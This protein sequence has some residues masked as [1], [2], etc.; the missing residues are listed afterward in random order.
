MLQTLT[1][2]GQA[3]PPAVQQPTHKAQVNF[4]YTLSDSFLTTMLDRHGVKVIGAYMANEGF[5][6]VHSAATSTAPATFIASARAE[7]AS[8]FTNGAGDGT[9]TRARDF[10][11]RHSTQDIGQDTELQTRAQSLVD[12]HTRLDQAR[13]NAQGTAALIYAVVVTGSKS[14]LV[15]LGE[16]R[17]VVDFEIADIDT[18][19]SWSQPSLQGGTTGQSGP[20]SFVPER[21]RTALPSVHTGPEESVVGVG[22]LGRRRCHWFRRDNSLRFVGLIQSCQYPREEGRTKWW[23]ATTQQSHRS[24]LHGHSVAGCTVSRARPYRSPGRVAT[25]FWQHSQS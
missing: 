4:G 21:G 8:G 14:A 18:D 5:Y 9:T 15:A 25:L 22:A 11:G 3:S 13:L 6:G 1:A 20:T 7:T 2:E 12:L 23:P 17:A 24:Q 16:E 10:V 19:V